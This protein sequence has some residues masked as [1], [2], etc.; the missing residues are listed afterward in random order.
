MYDRINIRHYIFIECIYIMVMETKN[1]NQ[2]MYQKLLDVTCG[3]Y[4]PEDLSAQQQEKNIN[5]LRCKFANLKNNEKA[6]EEFGDLQP[7]EVISQISRVPIEIV[8]ILAKEQGLILPKEINTDHI[9][10]EDISEDED[11]EEIYLDE[12]LDEDIMLDIDSEEDNDPLDNSPLINDRK[13]YIEMLLSMENKE[14]IMSLSVVAINN[15]GEASIWI[16]SSINSESIEELF[17]PL[18][19]SMISNGNPLPN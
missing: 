13:K 8:D 5:L 17:S 12:Y 14:E 16:P 19:K 18:I 7:A 9:S 10:L 1:K 2:Q 6:Q 11:E 3:I 4:N 15:N